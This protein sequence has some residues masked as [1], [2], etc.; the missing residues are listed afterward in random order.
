MRHLE[1][2]TYYSLPHLLSVRVSVGVSVSVSECVRECACACA[3]VRVYLLVSDC[4]GSFRHASGFVREHACAR[5]RVHAHVLIAVFCLVSH[6][7]LY[8]SAQVCFANGIT[9]S[10]DACDCVAC[11]C[12]NATGRDEF[13]SDKVH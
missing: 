11:D 8:F 3:Y 2:R 13:D 12:A 10:Q 9:C 5:W 7:K 1:M 6:F 4:D